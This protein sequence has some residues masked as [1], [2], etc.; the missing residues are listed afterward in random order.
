MAKKITIA[1]LKK[2]AKAAHAGITIKDTGSSIEITC[3]DNHKLKGS[4][5][6]YLDEDYYP[7]VKGSRVDAIKSIVA[8]LESGVER[9]EGPCDYCGREV[10]V[11]I[12]TIDG[13]TIIT[14]DLDG[15]EMRAF[16]VCNS[17]L[18]GLPYHEVRQMGEVFRFHLSGNLK[19]LTDDHGFYLD[20]QPIPEDHWWFVSLTAID[21]QY[22]TAE[23]LAAVSSASV[24][25]RAIAEIASVIESNFSGHHRQLFE[26][27]VEDS[28]ALKALR[29]EHEAVLGELN[30]RRAASIND[31]RLSR[32]IG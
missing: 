13:V 21:D 10:D 23:A 11:T 12:E 16:G 27:M 2:A 32:L 7:E 8:D 1:T 19:T 3:P 15:V 22:A 5:L 31:G 4:G 18:F 26:R 9:C 30:R 28:K 29:T 20:G 6:H 25:D 17:P 14:H 24:E